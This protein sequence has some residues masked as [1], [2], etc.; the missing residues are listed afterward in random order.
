MKIGSH[1][2]QLVV[3]R[4]VERSVERCEDDCSI[5]IVEL[6][7]EDES[8]CVAIY[9]ALESGSEGMSEC[10][11]TGRSHYDCGAQKLAMAIDMCDQLQRGLN[12][13][14]SKIN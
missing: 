4:S 7:V 6:T 8:A 10:V 1:V 3:E 12:A 9:A 13:V 2:F 14:R 11:I 5:K